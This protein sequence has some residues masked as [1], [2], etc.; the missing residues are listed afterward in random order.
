MG[1]SGG[2]RERSLGGGGGW[3]VGDGGGGGGGSRGSLRAGNKREPALQLFNQVI[4]Q[5]TFP[6]DALARIKNQLL[7]GFEY[8]K[9]NP[10]QLASLQ[11]FERLYGEHPGRYPE[12][13]EN[14][15]YPR[16]PERRPCPTRGE[17]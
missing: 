8:Q 10:G 3:E 6:E 1:R 9:Q 17:A 14:L 2:W 12:R 13:S 5:P 11:L 16:P 15:L 4:G 7:A